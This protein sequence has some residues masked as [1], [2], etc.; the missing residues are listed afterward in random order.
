MTQQ[1]EK[2]KGWEPFDKVKKMLSEKGEA[3]VYLVA[4]S[5]GLRAPKST[6]TSIQ[7]YADTHRPLQFV[8]LQHEEWLGTRAGKERSKSVRVPALRAKI[9]TVEAFV[10]LWMD[11]QRIHSKSCGC[12]VFISDGQEFDVRVMPTDQFPYGGTPN[13]LEQEFYEP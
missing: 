9:K 4:T 8:W 2:L 12:S 5:C 10:H 1:E 13:I 7:K 11:A 6:A 3:R